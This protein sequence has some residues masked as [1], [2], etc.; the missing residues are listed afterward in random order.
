MKMKLTSLDGKDFWT[1]EVP[2]RDENYK[3]H[4]CE[5]CNRLWDAHTRGRRKPIK[6][7]L[8]GSCRGYLS[9]DVHRVLCALDAPCRYCGDVPWVSYHRPDNVIISCENSECAYFMSTEGDKRLTEA[10]AV[11][12]WNYLNTGKLKEP[13]I[14]A[15]Y[16]WR[17]L[18]GC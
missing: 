1:V 12:R 2:A 13:R 5:Q 3:K 8:C 10:E 11:E 6:H 16:P 14:K 9:E 18:F 15:V 4:C 7:R 17:E